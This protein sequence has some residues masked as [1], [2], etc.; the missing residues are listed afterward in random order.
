MHVDLPPG[1]KTK[2]MFPKVHM[3]QT[4]YR[5]MEIYDYLVDL[6]VRSRWFPGQSPAKSDRIL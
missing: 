5:D 1:R 6:S 3:I 4:S 2:T